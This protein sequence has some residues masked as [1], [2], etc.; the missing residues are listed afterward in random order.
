M[1]KKMALGALAAVASAE[2]SSVS[3]FL[4]EGYSSGD[5]FYNAVDDQNSICTSGK[6]VDICVSMSLSSAQC[7]AT[8]NV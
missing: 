7:L 4:S 2:M 6:G 1:F 5:Y 3:E 8:N